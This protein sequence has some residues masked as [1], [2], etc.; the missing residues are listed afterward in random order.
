[1]L[2]KYPTSTMKNAEDY[3]KCTWLH[4]CQRSPPQYHIWNTLKAVV[5]SDLVQ[6]KIGITI[7]DSAMSRQSIVPPS[8]KVQCNTCKLIEKIHHVNHTFSI[9]AELHLKC[10]YEPEIFGL[11]CWQIWHILMSILRLNLVEAATYI[12]G[13]LPLIKPIQLLKLQSSVYF[14]YVLCQISFEAKVIFWEWLWTIISKPAFIWVG[15]IIY[16]KDHNLQLLAHLCNQVTSN[17]PCLKLACLLANITP[18][19]PIITF[20]PPIFR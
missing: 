3:D 14:R 2:R 1:M 7:P 8:K 10:T 16:Y 19:L 20:W 9:M 15:Y 11:A 13:K 4:T 5:A 18:C 6:T 17:G 12:R